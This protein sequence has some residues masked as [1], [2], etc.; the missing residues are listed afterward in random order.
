MFV[1]EQEEYKK[2]GLDWI[3][4]DFGM[5]LQATITLFEQVSSVTDLS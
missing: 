4:E 3:F 2:E 5:D 1:L